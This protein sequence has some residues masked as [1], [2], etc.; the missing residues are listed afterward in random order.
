MTEMAKRTHEAEHT[1]LNLVKR[2]QN[3]KAAKQAFLSN[4]WLFD[5]E[6]KRT[7]RRWQR[8]QV[9]DLE[10]VNDSD[11][12]AFWDFVKNLRRGKRKEIPKEVYEEDGVTVTDNL[13][14][15]LNRW[16]RDFGSLL[17]P[18]TNVGRRENSP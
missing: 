4:Q 2:K 9:L 12:N 6:I 18:P 1:F 11:P 5:K 3:A 15:V 14:Q 13:Q 8:A 7:K 17:A 10:A 16:E